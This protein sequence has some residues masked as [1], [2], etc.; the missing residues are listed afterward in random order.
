VFNG[1]VPLSKQL[2]EKHHS[3]LRQELSIRRDKRGLSYNAL[4]KLT[5][6]SRRALVGIEVGSSR[7]SV[8]T[9]LHICE[10]LGTTF[11]QFLEESISAHVDEIPSSIRSRA[12][13]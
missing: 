9:W 1:P 10:A 6:V 3:A 11:A 7:G 12:G 2:V 4:A 13:V 5:G 8:E